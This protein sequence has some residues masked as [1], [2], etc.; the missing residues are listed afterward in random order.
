MSEMV[1]AM[2]HEGAGVDDPENILLARE[3]HMDDV[4]QRSATLLAQR[5][6]LL[7]SHE[8]ANCLTHDGEEVVLTMRCS[9]KRADT[10]PGVCRTLTQEEIAQLYH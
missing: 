7:I 6:Q 4:V 9:I 1:E 8:I 3:G 5:A 10:K 2:M